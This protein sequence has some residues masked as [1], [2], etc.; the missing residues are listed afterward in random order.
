VGS[1]WIRSSTAEFIYP[2]DVVVIDPANIAV[3]VDTLMGRDLE[4]YSGTTLVVGHGRDTEAT[5]NPSDGRKIFTMMVHS[6]YHPIQPAGAAPAYG[7]F[8]IHP[9]V[10][11]VD[12]AAPVPPRALPNQFLVGAY[13]SGSIKAQSVVTNTP[14]ATSVHKGQWFTIGGRLTRFDATPQGGQKVSIYYVP[15]G[16]TK[17][18]FAGSPTTSSNGSFSLPVRSWYTGS[19]FANYAG[20]VFSTGIYQG[21]WVRVS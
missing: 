2:I 21:V 5:V 6:P 19:W 4:H 18:S 9:V 11:G 15:A 7:G 16:Q 13:R 10:R 17:A 8:E 12:P 3:A 14:S 1:R 20:S